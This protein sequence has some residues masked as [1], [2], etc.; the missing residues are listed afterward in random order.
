M[1]TF[2]DDIIH[3]MINKAVDIIDLRQPRNKS[4]IL[5]SEI[6]SLERRIEKETMLSSPKES[7]IKELETELKQKMTEK[8]KL[9]GA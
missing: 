5:E 6:S 4:Q 9:F 2:L 1:P 3:R 7:Y 8:S